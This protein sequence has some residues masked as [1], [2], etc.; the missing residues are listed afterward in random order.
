MN[1]MNKLIRMK[2]PFREVDRM[3][4]EF[5][6]FFDL[7][8][9]DQNRLLQLANEFSEDEKNYY[10]SID[11]PGINKKDI[12][13]QKSGEDRLIISAKREKEKKKENI[14]QHYSSIT[15]GSFTETYKFPTPISENIQAKYE[16]GILNL[17]I[18]KSA[19][20]KVKQIEIK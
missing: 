20:T 17:T 8:N 15:Y 18:P 7:F 13:I 5:D 19:Q 10:L 3:Q 11:L 16:N 6:Q 12:N 1:N 4:R 14:R 9:F 2:N